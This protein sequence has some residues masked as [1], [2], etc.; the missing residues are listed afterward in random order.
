MRKDILTEWEYGEGAIKMAGK[1]LMLR[2]EKRSIILGVVLE[3]L[4]TSDSKKLTDIKKIDEGVEMWESEII[5]IPR[6]KY[7]YNIEKCFG[8]LTPD[9]ML[10]SEW[11]NPENWN[12]RIF[13]KTKKKGVQHK[14]Q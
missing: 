3:S 6:R 12:K 13:D 9:Q 10:A 14:K 4:H 7:G 1:F 2:R 5:L 11:G 8:A